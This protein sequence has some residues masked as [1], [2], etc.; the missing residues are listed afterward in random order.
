MVFYVP[1]CKLTQPYDT[2]LPPTGV[3]PWGNPIRRAALNALEHHRQEEIVSSLLPEFPGSSFERRWSTLLA[4]L[5]AGDP[6]LLL[7]N[8]DTL[9]LGKAIDE[10]VPGIFAKHAVAVL[11]KCRKEERN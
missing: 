2:I 9:W 11:N 8:E 4:I 3:Y 7:E 6:F 5:E 10:T 1:L